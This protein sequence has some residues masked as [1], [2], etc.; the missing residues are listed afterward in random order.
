MS[1]TNTPRKAGPYTGNNVSVQY[2]FSFKVFAD[3]DLVVTRAVVATGAESTLVRTTDYTVTRNADQDVDP[4]GYITLATPLTSAQTL[5]LTSDVPATQSSVFTNLGGFYPAVLNS[6]LDRL[7]ILVQQIKEAVSRS[8]KL[9]VSTPTGFDAQ[10]PAPVPYG[11]IGFNGTADGFA[12]TDPSGSSALAGDL[13]GSGG[14]ALIGFGL[15]SVAAAVTLLQLKNAQWVSTSDFDG[16]D[17]TGAANSTAALNAAFAAVGSGTIVL[18]GTLKVSGA[19]LAVTCN[20]VML[21]GSKII[22]SGMSAG[23]VAFDVTAR[24]HHEGVRVEGVLATDPAN[25]TI[26]IRVAGLSAA[27]STLVN[28][29]AINCK[30][31]G[32]VRTFSVT[33]DDCRFN[34]NT[35]N[36]SA[37]AASS[38][39]Q[40]NDMKVRGGNY[41]NP[42]GTYAIKIG[43]PDF[44]TTVTAGQPHGQGVALNGFGVDAG[45]IKV[46]SVLN[47]QI[48]T[49]EP[50]Y[51]ENPTSGI[52][53]ELGTAGQDGYVGNVTVG[54]CFYST[55]KY[56]VF[57]N[58]GVNGL[59]VGPS[60]YTNVTKCA[61][62]V[63][64]D[65]YPFS[66]EKGNATSSFT[67]APEVHTGRRH[68]TYTAH[69]FTYVTLPS[70]G[71]IAGIQTVLNEPDWQIAQAEWKEGQT[72]KRSSPTEYGYGR[73]Y[74]TPATGKAGS[75]NSYVFSLTTVTDAKDF[76]GGDEYDAGGLGG[77][78]IDRVDYELGKV[79][80][81][82]SSTG[83]PT[84]GTL[85]QNTSAWHSVT[86][87]T[88]GAPPTTGSWVKGDVCENRNSTVGQAKRWQRVT[89]GSGNVAG[90]DWISEGN[91]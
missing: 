22:T 30:Y 65:I 45:S 46:D 15:T 59:K 58:A 11:V 76:N 40:I 78:V 16:V 85:S 87:T 56:A 39:V 34:S 6:A 84:G 5:T 33:L 8:L 28:C 32:V 71:V 35:C 14:A 25:G 44:A 9:A 27:R 67:L 88:T 47:V 89:T 64:T 49:A 4:G 70:D 26:G 10:L 91:L 69:D 73:R 61:L 20:T 54:P 18:S 23:A 81:S 36:L 24:T 2:V 50:I 80:L 21:P 1:V 79:Y 19:G 72:L 52:G 7:T 66:Y 75:L 51:Y 17:T 31:G 57:C 12:V 74:K 68:A 29:S 83:T 43:D 82:D 3:T 90:T 13:A 63:M 77:G 37:S 53:L 42:L 48:G 62:Y 86:G 41:A 38:A 55:M 60:T